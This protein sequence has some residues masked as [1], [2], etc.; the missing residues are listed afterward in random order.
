MSVIMFDLPL[1]L[2]EHHEYCSPAIAF[3][4]FVSMEAA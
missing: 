3:S 4:G 2:M 1:V